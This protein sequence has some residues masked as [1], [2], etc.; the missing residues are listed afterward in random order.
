MSTKAAL[1]RHGDT[2]R[3]AAR[4]ELQQMV[5]KEVFEGVQWGKL[6]LEEK[7][8][9][10]GSFMFF[11]EKFLADGTLNKVKAR[12]VANGKDESESLY[13]DTNSPTA[14]LITVFSVLAIAA[15]KRRVMGIGDVPGAYLNADQRKKIIMMLGKE[16]GDILCSIDS[17]YSQYRR[18]D[19][20]I[21]VILR[22]ALYG[23]K[24]SA[25]LWYEVLRAH[26]ERNGFVRSSADKCLFV[27]GSTWIVIYVDDFIVVADDQRGVE[28]V[29]SML[30][31]QFGKMNKTIGKEFT[32]LGM[33][34]KVKD[35]VAEVGM[36]NYVRDMLKSWSPSREYSVP[37][38]ASLFDVDES[39]ELLPERERK[40][41]HTMV[42]KLL[43]LAK[44]AR[45]DI[46]VAVTMLT[47]RVTK[48]TREDWQKLERILGYLKRFPDLKVYLSTDEV[49]K[50]GV[51]V[52]AAY[53]VHPDAKSHTGI[54]STL[55][56]GLIYVASVKQ[57][58]TARSSYEAEIN[59]ASDAGPPVMW[60][61]TMLE[62][63]GHPCRPALLYQ[64]NKAA[65]ATL[66][67]GEV[68]GK[69]SKHIKIRGMW[70]LEKM[71]EREIEPV[72]V[73]T[74]DMVADFFSKPVVGERF[75]QMSK[76]SRGER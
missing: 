12:L 20:R 23:C 61:L 27:S 36:D 37:A 45:P 46:L 39:S 4:K 7:K 44:R 5:D 63:L 48:A 58:N 15:S 13:E 65:I 26:L 73:G 67:N 14:S 19:G 69:L 56:R 28:S 18:K 54:F 50:L 11:K 21:P 66:K 55:G 57:K 25:L 6:T 30:E 51:W 8:A 33:N 71:A 59:G 29:F 72:W 2:A 47:T 16:I 24:E 31:N 22:K 34:I 43:Y 62:D 74:D 32:Y 75:V 53:G 40:R 42:A 70:L 3:E 52:D 10:I 68:N 64:D 41:F 60:T 76:V 1:A 17:K 35:G 49:V 38:T 9:A